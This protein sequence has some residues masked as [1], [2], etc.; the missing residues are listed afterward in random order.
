MGLKTVKAVANEIGYAPP[1][2][3]AW[4]LRNDVLKWNNIY[5]LNDLQVEELRV[6]KENSIK[7]LNGNPNQVVVDELPEDTSN[8]YTT[9]QVADLI[10]K[11]PERIATWCS[12]NGVVKYPYSKTS[13]MLKRYLLTEE[14]KQSCQKDF[15][16]KHIDDNSVELLVE[17]EEIDSLFFGID[18]E[19]KPKEKPSEFIDTKGLEHNFKKRTQLQLDLPQPKDNLS[20]IKQTI[21]QLKLKTQLA[22]LDLKREQL[23]LEIDKVMR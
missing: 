2:I 12:A 20:V 22:E 5:L 4:C 9:K 16:W 14:E 13:K 18:I 7:T 10:G 8:L 15:L 3:S 23:A 6:T 21:H 19:E 1:T 11:P 17:P